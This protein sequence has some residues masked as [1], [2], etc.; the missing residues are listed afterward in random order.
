M[1]T[2]SGSAA[3]GRVAG[4]LLAGVLAAGVGAR[5]ATGPAAGIAEAIDTHLA[6]GRGAAALAETERLVAAVWAAVPLD[7]SAVVLVDAPPAGYGLYQPRAKGPFLPG[8]PIRIYAEPVGFAHGH[9]GELLEIAFDV[10]LAIFDARGRRIAAI[11]GIQSMRFASRRPI[12]EFPASITYDW[13]GAGPGAYRLV[14]TLRDRHSGKAG[15]FELDIEIAPP[16]AQP[17][18]AP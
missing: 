3:R 18:A 5:A 4:L 6:A 2:T 14:T 9:V 13:A 7:F 10:D 16:A 8:E 1:A 17:P 15:S 12:R 11:P